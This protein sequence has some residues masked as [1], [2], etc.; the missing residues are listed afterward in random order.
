MRLVRLLSA[1]KSL[2]GG[3]DHPSRYRMGEPGML[4]KF[5]SGKNPFQAGAKE[6]QPILQPIRPP[7]PD[8]APLTPAFSRPDKDGDTPLGAREALLVPR[9]PALSPPAPTAP[10]WRESD[11]ERESGGVLKHSSANWS[12]ALRSISRGWIQALKARIPRG[13]AQ[14]AR[15]AGPSFMGP[16]VQTELSLDKIKVVRNDLSDMDL[17][18]IP[19]RPPPAR[20]ETGRMFSGS[21]SGRMAPAADAPSRY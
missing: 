5:G 20:S 9:A 11:G 16:P 17:E 8:A 14:A 4:P 2:V 6:Q 21:M 19:L 13:A 7:Q 10:Q 1:G 3:M 12:S 15:S 18:V